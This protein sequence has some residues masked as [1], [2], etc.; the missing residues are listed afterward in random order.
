MMAM[1]ASIANTLLGLKK[2]GSTS[3]LAPPTS[4]IGLASRSLPP[5]PC[6]S[7]KVDIIDTHV[8]CLKRRSLLFETRIVAHSLIIANHFDT[9]DNIFVTVDASILSPPPLYP[10][11]SYHILPVV[12]LEK[13]Y[14]NYLPFLRFTISRMFLYLT[15]FF[16]S[17]S[18]PFA[19]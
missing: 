3:C 5:S 12:S 1:K 6:A 19:T 17:Y 7:R 11:L 4:G 13:I 14:K 8:L 18:R 2:A 10:I 9:N 15:N 16:A